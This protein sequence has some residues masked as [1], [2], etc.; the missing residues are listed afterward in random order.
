MKHTLSVSHD[1]QHPSILARWSW[2][3]ARLVELY[4]LEALPVS[5]TRDEGEISENFRLDEDDLRYDMV[6]CEFNY[7]WR[8]QTLIF[9]QGGHTVTVTINV[10]DL[11]SYYWFS[12]EPALLDAG[13]KLFVSF[14]EQY[15][16]LEDTCPDREAWIAACADLD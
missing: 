9:Q 1:L 15:L 12:D 2:F 11:Y 10:D 3:R 5:F 14:K 16:E 7:S 6:P 4:G 13:V 8:C